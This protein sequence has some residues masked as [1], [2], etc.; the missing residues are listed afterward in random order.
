MYIL[1]MYYLHCNMCQFT[2]GKKIKDV[3]G[4]KWKFAKDTLQTKNLH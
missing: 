4:I 1:I 3:I 2:V